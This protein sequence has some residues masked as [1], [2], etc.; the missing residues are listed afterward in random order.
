MINIENDKN[1]A[2]EINRAI[3]GSKSLRVLHISAE[4]VDAFIWKYEEYI[5]ENGIGYISPEF[6]FLKVLRALKVAIA[7]RTVKVETMNRQALKMQRI[8]RENMQAVKALI[9]TNELRKQ[10]LRMESISKGIENNRKENEFEHEVSKDQALET[11]R[12]WQEEGKQAKDIVTQQGEEMKQLFGIDE[13]KDG[14]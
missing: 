4:S 13:N 14:E 5:R 11:M 7:K 2:T 1:V 6:R 3:V 12:I 10:N 8:E 9:L